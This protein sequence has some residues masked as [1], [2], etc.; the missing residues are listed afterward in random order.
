MHKTKLENLEL[1]SYKRH[2]WKSKAVHSCSCLPF[3]YNKPDLTNYDLLLVFLKSKFLFLHVN[4]KDK[5]SFIKI[6]TIKVNSQGHETQI[7]CF[8]LKFAH[9]TVTQ[10]LHARSDP[11]THWPLPCRWS[12]TE[13]QTFSH[14]FFL[15][16][17]F[18]TED[19]RNN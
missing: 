18:A 4:Y 12:S 9:S 3:G 13:P 14:I 6:L 2:E 19:F 17:S 5:C 1:C 8:H 15:L 16:R 11:L 10:N 7:E